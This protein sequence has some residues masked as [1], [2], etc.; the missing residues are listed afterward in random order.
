MT[1]GHLIDGMCVRD[2]RGDVI[3]QVNILGQI[4]NERN[5]L[6]LRADERLGRREPG[7]RPYHDYLEGQIQEL[8]GATVSIDAL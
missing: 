6:S 3:G 2:I 7:N 8:Q 1:P 5:F 4:L